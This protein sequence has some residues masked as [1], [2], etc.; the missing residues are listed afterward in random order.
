MAG[1]IAK[2][3]N[4]KWRA[5]YRDESGKEH[6]RHF[7]RK[8]DAQ[9]WLDAVTSAV[10]TGTYADPQAGRIT[11]AAFFGEWSARQVWAPGTVLAM[12]LAA[13]SVPFAGK[14]MKQV[15]RSDVET[16][17]KQMNAAGLAPGTIKTR[18]VNVRSVF[19]AAVKDRVIG[20]DPT[21]A[22]RL[23]RGRRPDIAMS[24][25]TPEDV[26][27]LMAVA[28]ERFQPFIA[29]CAFAGLR[30]GEAAGVQLGD[31]DFLRKS[32][33]VSR[34]VQRVN[35]GA[36]DVRAPKYG[37]ERVVYL[38]DTLVTVLAKHIAAHGTT[39]NDRWLFAGDGDN[40]P[41]QNTVSSQ[42]PVRRR[43]VRHQ[44]PRPAALLRL[45]PHRRRVRRRDRPALA[46]SLESHDDPQHVRPSLADRRGPDKEGRGVDHVRIARR[47][48][49]STRRERD[50]HRQMSPAWDG[51][52]AS[53]GVNRWR[54]ITPR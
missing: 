3:A 4:G 11:F 23:P 36:I 46:R 44:A 9:Q 22:V 13:R 2:R 25:P 32:L 48:R 38:A 7:D 18:Y 8:I 30:L 52:L 21:D 1:N 39:G 19:R 51:G 35:G 41:H 40:P 34:Q 31:V 5:R 27:Q 42:D 33:K 14:P 53:R 24:I 29:L 17:I 15:R 6:S 10:V 54:V 28:D 26:G 43:T 50:E 49:R 20:T 37:S 12:S 45:R 16:W 47:A